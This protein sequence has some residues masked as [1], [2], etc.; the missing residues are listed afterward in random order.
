MLAFKGVGGGLTSTW[1]MLT[2]FCAFK[3]PP[4]EAYAARQVHTPRAPLGSPNMPTEKDKG[5]GVRQK[6]QEERYKTLRAPL[7]KSDQLEQY[8][9]I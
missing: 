9:Y 8:V 3:A 1:T 4:D 7:G 5:G 2:F 6:I